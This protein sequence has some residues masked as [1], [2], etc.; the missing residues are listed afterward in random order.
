MQTLKTISMFLIYLFLYLFIYL[1]LLK[2]GSL[3]RILIL[4]LVSFWG[5][6]VFN[7]VKAFV[8]ARPFKPQS[9]NILVII[10]YL[11]IEPSTCFGAYMRGEGG[12]EGVC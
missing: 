10:L 11:S 6:V 7:G 4:N 1:F 3:I 2:W 5:L 9:P 8:C 12:E